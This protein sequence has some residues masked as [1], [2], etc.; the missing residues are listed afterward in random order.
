MK[1]IFTRKNIIIG[2]VVILLI[3]MAFVAYRLFWQ[4]NSK[5][6]SD[7]INEEADKY[8]TDKAAVAQVIRDGVE[9]ILASHNLTQQVLRSAKGSGVPKEQELVHAAIMQCKSFGYLAA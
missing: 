8:G 3:A 1:N 2:L 6:V 9:H 5:D 7:Y 4:F